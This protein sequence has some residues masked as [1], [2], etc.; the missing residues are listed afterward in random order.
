MKNTKT[1]PKCSSTS[2][3]RIDGAK[4]PNGNNFQADITFFSQITVN[5]NRYICCQ[6]GYSEEWIDREDLPK[7]VNGKIAKSI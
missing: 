4:G 5:V 1:C 3:V 7:I 2:I 6:C